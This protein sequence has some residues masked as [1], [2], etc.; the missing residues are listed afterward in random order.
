VVTSSRKGTN[1]VHDIETIR[2][3]LTAAEPSAEDLP[4]VLDAAWEA[5]NLAHAVCLQ[6]EERSPASF[7]AFAFAATA[8]AQ[9]RQQ[10]MTAPS[11]PPASGTVTYDAAA[12]PADLDQTADELASLA[13]ALT[14]RLSLAAS[15]SDDPGDQAACADA[16][17]K[18]NQI[19][20]LLAR[21]PQR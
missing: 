5:F 14:A 2:A 18:A 21:D 19:Y 4:D 3:R 17:S 8:A 16:A 1:I 11:L 6:C 12:V 10:I 9:G 13:R 7:A 15:R 20:E